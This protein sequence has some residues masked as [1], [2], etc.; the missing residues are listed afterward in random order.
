MRG[1]TTTVYLISAA[2]LLPF[3]PGL[4]AQNADICKELDEIQ[5]MEA[6]HAAKI[7]QFRSSP[8]TQ[9]YD[10][11]YHRLEWSVDPAV[12]YIEGTVTSWF[13]PLAAGFNLINFDLADN[14]QVNEVTYRGTPVSFTHADNLLQIE[15]PEEIQPGL[16]DSVSVSY[17]GAPDSEGFGSFE[18]ALH[19]DTVPAMWTL[20]EPFGA[21][22]WW[23]CKQ[24]LLDKIDSI[25]IYVT[26]PEAYKA[27]TNGLLLSESIPSEGF[28]TYHWRHRYPIA[29][30]LI[31][32]AVSNYHT[33]TNYVYFSDTDSMPVLNY[34]YPEDRE[35]AEDQLPVTVELMDLFN[36]LFG[37]YPFKTEKY[38]HAQFGWGGGMEHQTMSSM[39]SFSFALQAHE[40]AHQWFGDKVTCG[41][42]EDIWLNEGFAN[43]L[44]GLT[45]EFLLSD[46]DFWDIYKEQTI[47]RVT[48][49]PG[50]SVRVDDTTNVNRIFNSRLS[51]RKG[52]MLLHMLRWKMGD[53]DFF[54]A[55]RN[56]LEDPELAY[57][58]AKTPD[59]QRHLESVSGEDL[60]EFFA[61]WYYGEG[62]PSYQLY[63]EAHGGGVEV[64][65][66]QTTSHPSVDFF[67][68]PVPVY[69][70]DGEQDTLVVLDHNFSGQ[71][72]LFDFDF[73][74]IEVIIDPELWLL[75]KDN[76]I[77]ILGDVNETRDYGDFIH[78]YPSPAQDILMIEIQANSLSV[79][80]WNW[81]LTDALGRIYLN[82]QKLSM[83]NQVDVS[84]FQEG[85][86]FLFF[87]SKDGAIMKQ[88]VKAR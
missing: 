46:T 21:L 41:S 25:D 83:N 19:A 24:D 58:F 55:A 80:E 64:M 34:V 76:T 57:G 20:S 78:L 52:A 30:Y 65:L 62:Y 12:H 61:D 48:Q 10:L 14:M 84:T 33:F 72:F 47:D 9:D 37:D 59:L 22:T 69:F 86:Y 29:T 6:Q 31:S 18:T 85:M 38:G 66:E 54:Q 82:N 11:V 7:L 74:P 28:R 88:F 67:E 1:I 73:F 79:D 60:D 50:G 43:Y 56:Y 2:L 51:Y 27:G 42:W 63:Y 3:L 13:K 70:T 5:E 45:Y 81:S 4:R 68:M 35:V 87:N 23:P 53:E 15:L 17:E 44:T 26:T 39:G 16:L 36:S 32:L 40:L 49:E 75:S 71:H 8:A 77:E